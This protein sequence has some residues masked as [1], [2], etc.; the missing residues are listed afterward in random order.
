MTPTEAQARANLRN[1]ARRA[2]RHAADAQIRSEIELKRGHFDVALAHLYR[3]RFNLD[4]AEAME[5]EAQS[6][7]WEKTP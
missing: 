6:G 5:R 3:V 7:V 1:C 2:R 4:M